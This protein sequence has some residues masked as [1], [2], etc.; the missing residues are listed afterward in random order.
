M[1]DWFR[2]RLAAYLLLPVLAVGSLVWLRHHAAPASPRVA[3]PK[4]RQT[5]PP[6]VP[7]LEVVEHVLRGHVIEI[8]GRSDSNA[9]VMINGEQAALVFPNSSFKHFVLVPEG[10]SIVTITAM[11]DAGGV[12]TQRVEVQVP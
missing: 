3:A 4:P 5:G 7:T 9:T 6:R 12:N 2:I 11:N 1:L 10:S 8:E